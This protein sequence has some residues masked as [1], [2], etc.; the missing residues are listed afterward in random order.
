[1]NRDSHKEPPQSS[2][3]AAE[4]HAGLLHGLMI[5]IRKSGARRASTTNG[6]GPEA[7]AS[8]AT[9]KSAPRQSGQPDKH[10]N[11]RNG[12]VDQ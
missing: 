12:S 9:A 6:R 10:A 5:A 3:D 4:G 2:Q 7:P 8:R 1:M 11:W